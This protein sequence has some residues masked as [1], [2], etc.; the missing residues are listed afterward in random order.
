MPDDRLVQYEKRDGLAIIRVNNPPV[1]ALSTRMLG[2]LSE[3]FGW[4]EKDA[5]V[6]AIVLIGSGRTFIAGAD[7]RELE[8]GAWGRGTG[9]PDAH[10]LLRR[11][12][13]STTPI[14]VAIHGTA[15][16]GGV[17]VAMAGHYRVAVPGA[18][19]GLPEVNL[20]IIP[21]AEGTQRLPRLVGVQKALEMC[22]SGRPIAAADALSAG[23]IDEIVEGDLEAGAATF[24]R[25]VSARGGP[26]PRTS[27][28]NDRIGTPES[29]APLL[30]G[31]RELARRSRRNQIAPLAAVDAIEAATVL[32]FGEGI[33]RE[34]QLFERCL[35]SEQ[36]KALLHVFFAE[37]AVAKVP[38]LPPDTQ[39]RPVGTV[40]IIGAGTMGGGIA[41]ACANAGLP[42]LLVDSSQ[43]A[44]DAGLARVRANYDTSF[45]RGRFSE[46]EVE[47]RL[48]LIAPQ[49]DYAGLEQADLVIEAVYE[50]MEL[51]KRIFA[52]LDCVV[53]PGCVLGTNT[54]TLDIDEIAAATS[55]PRD[56][57][58]LHFFSPANVMRLLEI[59]RGRET[60]PDVIATGMAL[61]KQL[62]KVGVLVGNGPGF[63]GNRML[64]PYMYE[65]QFLVEEGATPEQVDAVLTEFGMAMGI[66]AVD[67]MA[68]LDVAWRVRRE[69]NPFSGEG[70]RRPQVA[71]RLYEMGRFGQK[72]GAGWYRY[73]GRQPIPDPEV[74]ALI[75]RVSEEEGIERRSISPEE[76]L[77]R[78]VYSLINEG[79]RAL[80]EGLASR[81][82]D[83]DVIYVNGY[84][85]PA[86]R[87]GPMFHADRVG[88]GNI[89]ARLADLERQHG[90]RWRPS[91][92]LV[93]LAAEERTF[94]DYD[95]GHEPA[96]AGRPA[97]S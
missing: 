55:R 40:A 69:L 16:G 62:R 26:H 6:D 87:G 48:G 84:G 58:G 54:S 17:E 15:L 22:V 71:D 70:E 79:A 4:A 21:G 73:Q 27:A 97:A 25:A 59:V 10:P 61:A 18:Q 39:P 28:R 9:G 44:L 43:D 52:E 5:D 2:E 96:P 72:T 34:R 36:C 93:R 85:F 3:A 1:N 35:A 94:R 45:K 65:A 30:E 90:R 64:F 31:G 86:W 67:D 80:E 29:A 56:V 74:H 83:I 88:L 37:R 75:E 82:S 53:K 42:V 14:V 66:F 12:E 41:M 50:S 46:A 8:T 89:A 24:A 38:D 92:L 76:I 78:T 95:A 60:A 19:L 13:E 68:G 91:A 57:I 33:R 11:M 81:A 49:L 47:Q 51:K 63:V 7:I 77:E 23:L 32:P 20:G